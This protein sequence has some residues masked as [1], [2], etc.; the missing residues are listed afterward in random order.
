MLTKRPNP[1]E[2]REFAMA[3]MIQKENNNNNNKKKC[4]FPREACSPVGEAYKIIEIN[5]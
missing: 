4:V 1:G 3:S 5:V 2:L